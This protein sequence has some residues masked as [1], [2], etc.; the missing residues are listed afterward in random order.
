MTATT[1]LP[2]LEILKQ[3]QH[4]IWSSG[5]YNRIAALTVPVAE[6]LVAAAAPPPGAK[7][8][9]VATGTGHVA[10]AAARQFS[11]VSAV[12]YVAQLVAVTRRRASAED[13]TVDAREGDAEHLPYADGEFDAVLSALGVMFTADHARAA[14]ELV[15]VSRPGGTIGL[16]SWTPTGFVGQLLKTVGRHVPPPAAAQPPTRWGTVEGVRELLG[17]RVEQVRFEERSVTQRFRS[18]EH[19][20]DF[21]LDHYGPTRKAAEQLGDD[22]RT[23][24]RD[25]IV[26]LAESADRGQNGSFTSDWAYLIAVATPR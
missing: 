5:D 26:A 23:A 21:F 22:G 15:R 25:D 8:L 9:D 20:A 14:A 6:A 19:F 2:A 18:P 10:L 13:L 17:D 12:D 7:V 11:R 3:K 16:A 24:L 1:D 4:A